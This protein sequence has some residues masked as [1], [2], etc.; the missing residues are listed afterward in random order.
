MNNLWFQSHYHKR[1]SNSRTMKHTVNISDYILLLVGMVK[2]GE[3][4]PRGAGSSLTAYNTTL[5]AISKMVT[6][7]PGDLKMTNGVWK[8][9]YRRS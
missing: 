3:Y 2:V 7:A 1:Y 6:R 9:I 8:D 5:P 4:Q